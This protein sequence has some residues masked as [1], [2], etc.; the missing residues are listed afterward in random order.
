MQTDYLIIGQGISGTF[1]SRALVQAGRSVLVIDQYNPRS[2]SRVASGVIN[3]VT[4]RRIV[5]TW[6]IDELLPFAQNAYE[7]IGQ[8]LGIQCIAEKDIIDCFA[9]PQMRL[10]FTDRYAQDPEYLSLP[11]D[12]ND[13]HWRLRYDFGYG[14]IRPAYWINME[15]LLREYR[16]R[17]K[18]NNQLIEDAFDISLLEVKEDHV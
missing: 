2:A 1:L 13:Q 16:R 7:A 9:T 5:K 14:I 10:A 18:E 15:A 17:L 3:P 8:D 12:E 11:A 6:M 4:G